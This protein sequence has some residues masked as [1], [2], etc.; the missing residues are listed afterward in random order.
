[1][2]KIFEFISKNTLVISFAIIIVAFLFSR[3]P[4]FLW[5][6]L[7]HY[8]FDSVTYFSE[9]SR[10][11]NGNLPDSG[12]L[13]IGYPIFLTIT[14]AI[15]IESV[16]IIQNILLLIV[17][18]YFVKV[19]NNFYKS[20]TLFLSLAFCVVILS[21]KTI[22]YDVGFHT[23]SL[24]RISIILVTALFINALNSKKI[25]HWII[26]STSMVLPVLFRSNGIFIYFLLFTLII[27]FILNK[28]QA[29]YY[30]AFFIPIIFL[31]LVW[32]TYN[33]KIDGYFLPGNP[34]RYIY[35]A[36]YSSNRSDT[37]VKTENNNFLIKKAKLITR[38][39]I[40][41]AVR[42]N[43][44]Y[45]YNIPIYYNQ[46]YIEKD[47]T[48]GYNVTKNDWW[49]VNFDNSL[50]KLI[51]REY[52]DTIPSKELTK[53][54]SYCNVEGT[55]DGIPVK[56]K[57]SQPWLFLYHNY[58]L[59]HNVFFR[60]IIWLLLL[61][62]IFSKTSLTLLKTRFKDKGAFIVFCIA[63]IQ[64]FSALFA[65]TH[66]RFVSRYIEVTSFV[67]YILPVFFLY[68]SNTF[69]NFYNKIKKCFQEKQ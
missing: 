43:N 29:K 8:S 51:F 4:F 68:Y 41:I 53:N 25:I 33:Y 65:A 15:S 40:E 36:D 21:S 59:F 5:F 11:L 35:V 14:S 42:E 38:Q 20:V 62:Y 2:K 46:L 13:P 24:Y 54:I 23:E 10:Y 7:P 48:L 1:M 19:T 26:F 55:I 9:A 45:Y 50:K 60:N 69:R 32:S 66:S 28:F 12:F 3:L 37:L 44:F 18:L 39:F 30:L 63:L 58:H 27:Y 6:T 56:Q 49:E 61:F 34:I 57:Y 64:I 52:I 22:S 47:R 31:N 17:I 67:Y 16:L